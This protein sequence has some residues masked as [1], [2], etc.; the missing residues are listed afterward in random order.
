MI[1]P[2]V[3]NFTKNEEDLCHTGCTYNL[4]YSKSRPP[5]SEFLM[6]KLQ[7]YLSFKTSF[8]DEMTS[9]VNIPNCTPHIDNEL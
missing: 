3:P 1:V 4:V 8:E 9:Q 6:Q 2:E 7:V 5:N